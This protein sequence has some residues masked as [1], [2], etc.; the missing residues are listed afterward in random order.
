M[1]VT[2]ICTALAGSGCAG[3]GALKMLERCDMYTPRAI[4]Q[5]IDLPVAVR[6]AKDENLGKIKKARQ[7]PV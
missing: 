7:L 6:A 2:L 3:V 1:A 5:V 4:G